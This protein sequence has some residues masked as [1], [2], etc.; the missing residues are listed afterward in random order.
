MGEIDALSTQGLILEV[1][2]AG[3]ALIVAP[4]SRIAWVRILCFPSKRGSDLLV[5]RCEGWLWICRRG[6]VRLRAGVLLY[7]IEEG[8]H[9]PASGWSFVLLVIVTR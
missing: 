8:F 5:V 9:W 3:I 6:G 1:F 2:G 4:M 7:V